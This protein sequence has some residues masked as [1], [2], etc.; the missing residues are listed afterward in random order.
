[1]TEAAENLLLVLIT[2]PSKEVAEQLARQ[3]L[4]ERLAACVNLV[5]AV[6]SLYW[7]QG[8]LQSDTETLMLVKTRKEGFDERFIPFV[9]AHHPYQVPEIL[10]LP[11][12]A[13]NPDYLQWAIDETSSNIT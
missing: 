13:G 12:L 11:I 2:A 8:E 4:Q 5:D 1:M 9:K 6:Q 10:A 7:W 3:L